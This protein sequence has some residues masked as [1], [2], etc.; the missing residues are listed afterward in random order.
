MAIKS[1]NSAHDDI[2]NA[3]MTSTFLLQ[4][5]K[6]ISSPTHS[7]SSPHQTHVDK[8]WQDEINQTTGQ[9]YK[10]KAEYDAETQNRSN[11][12]YSKLTP[13][14]RELLSKRAVSEETARRKNV[15]K[16]ALKEDMATDVAGNKL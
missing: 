16:N 1:N 5:L 15:I 8:A 4:H 2:T 9:P 6:L 3:T 13:K 10:N 12:S 14:Q 11:P 7:I